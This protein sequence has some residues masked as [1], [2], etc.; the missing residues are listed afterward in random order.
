MYDSRAVTPQSQHLRY[1]FRRVLKIRVQGNHR[2][3]GGI[4]QTGVQGRFLILTGGKTRCHIAAI[5]DGQ[6]HDWS[7]GRRLR[8]IWIKEVIPA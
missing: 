8:T 1:Q 2:L 6:L 4:F 7:Q 5:V 3:A